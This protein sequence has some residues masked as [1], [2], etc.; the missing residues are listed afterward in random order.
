MGL[1][2]HIMFIKT[3]KQEK[4]NKSPVQAHE[5]Q[6]QPQIIQRTIFFLD[7]IFQNKPSIHFD[8]LQLF[9]FVCLWIS[10]KLNDSRQFDFN[11]AGVQHFTKNEY[12]NQEINEMEKIILKELKYKVNLVTPFD[13]LE[14]LLAL[15][16]QEPLIN[17][18]YSKLA[19]YTEK[20]Q[21]NTDFIGFSPSSI[22]IAILFYYFDDLELLTEIESLQKLTSDLELNLYQVKEVYNYLYNYVEPLQFQ[23]KLR[24]Q[25]ENLEKLQIL[26]QKQQSYQ[27]YCLQQ[28]SKKQLNE[29]LDTLDDETYSQ[30][31]EENSQDEQMNN[32]QKKQQK[33]KQKQQQKQKSQQQDLDFE[34]N[35]DEEEEQEQEQENLNNNYCFNNQSFENYDEEFFQQ[36]KKL[37]FTIN[38]PNFITSPMFYKENHIF[39]QNIMFSQESQQSCLI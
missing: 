32:S 28:S 3:Q 38:E 39:S 4:N 37:K 25:L 23:G 2:K 36:A 27:L 13:I 26:Q 16:T 5:C 29:S 12:S 17:Q 15:Y 21:L 14:T 10:S 7:L 34:C 19:E 33:L 22:A 24:Y 6:L 1:R 8:N 35:E 31:Q 11:I 18:E 30:Q 9:G 20:I